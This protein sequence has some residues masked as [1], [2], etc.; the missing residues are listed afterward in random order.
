MSVTVCDNAAAVDKA[1]VVAALTDSDV[2][3]VMLL[4]MTLKRCFFFPKRCFFPLLMLHCYC[5]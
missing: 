2:L 1:A 4:I 5:C 3:L